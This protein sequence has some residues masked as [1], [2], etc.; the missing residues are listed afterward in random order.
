MQIS[1]DIGHRPMIFI[2]FNPDDYID[3]HQKKITSCWNANQLGLFVVKR[4]KQKEWKERI[5]IL[6]NQ[7]EYWLKNIP[8]KTI[9]VV[10]LFYNR[11]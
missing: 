9:E 4:N 1:Q 6:L 11:N 3:E 8:S 10:E 2:R 7:I 5:T